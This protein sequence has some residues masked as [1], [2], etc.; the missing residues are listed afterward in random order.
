[1]KK[2]DKKMVRGGK[3]WSFTRGALRKVLFSK[4]ETQAK[5]M[6]VKQISEISTFQVTTTTAT[7]IC[8]F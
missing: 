8:S 6:R 2:W 5:S 7:R 1:M 3:G 4:T